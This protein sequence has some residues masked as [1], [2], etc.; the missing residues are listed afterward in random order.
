MQNKIE[1]ITSAGVVGSMLGSFP[2]FTD[3]HHTVA[4]ISPI[5][6][7]FTVCEK[8]EPHP[9]SEPYSPLIVSHFSIESVSASGTSGNL[10]GMID[11][12]G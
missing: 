5:E 9:H 11:F 10:L 3:N 6:G 8:H 4:E 2:H 7:C 1:K 12:M